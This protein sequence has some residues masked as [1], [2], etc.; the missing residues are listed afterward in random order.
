M[1]HYLCDFPIGFLYTEKFVQR[2]QELT[3]LKSNAKT[4]RIID[5]YTALSNKHCCK[6]IYP[7]VAAYKVKAWYCQFEYINI[8]IFCDSLKIL[9]VESQEFI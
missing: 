4:R 3:T 9:Q 5:K 8:Y 6:R 2:C 7:C 1:V